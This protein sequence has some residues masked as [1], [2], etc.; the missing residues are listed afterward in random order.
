MP[1]FLRLNVLRG[2]RKWSGKGITLGSEDLQIAGE[3]VEQPYPA[4]SW[5]SVVESRADND[6]FFLRRDVDVLTPI[7]GGVEIAFASGTL[8]APPE[9]LVVVTIGKKVRILS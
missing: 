5:N 8:V 6:Y 2:M 4:P 1:L 3:V 9:V 7:T